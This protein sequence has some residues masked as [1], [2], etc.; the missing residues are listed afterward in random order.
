MFDE[1]NLTQK[2][3]YCMIPLNVTFQERQRCRDRKQINSCQELRVRGGADYTEAQR[4]F[5]GMVE[6]A[7][8]L[9]GD[10]LCQ[11]CI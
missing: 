4:E 7:S 2:A 6:I 10:A 3:S 8:I 1:R 9:I 5:G 11:E